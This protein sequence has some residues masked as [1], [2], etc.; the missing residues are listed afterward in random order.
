SSRTCAC[1]FCLRNRSAASL[2][3]EDRLLAWK[4]TTSSL[5]TLQLV[6]VMRLPSSHTVFAK[7]PNIQPSSQIHGEEDIRIEFRPA[8]AQRTRRAAVMVIL[9]MPVQV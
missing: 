5:R 7:A 3:T 4:M 1:G 6:I 8:R 2:K 9:E